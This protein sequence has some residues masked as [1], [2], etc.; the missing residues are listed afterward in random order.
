[1]ESR[2]AVLQQ[3]ARTTTASL[4]RIEQRMDPLAADHRAD[5]RWLRGIRLGGFGALLGAMAHGFPWL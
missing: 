4:E 1:M 5:F 2:V 3:I